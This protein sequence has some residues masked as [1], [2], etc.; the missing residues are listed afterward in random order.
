MYQVVK[1]QK[2][3]KLL[4]VSC[5]QKWQ[6]TN[7]KLYVTEMRNSFMEMTLVPD[8]ETLTD[9]PVDPELPPITEAALLYNLNESLSGTIQIIMNIN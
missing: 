4:L 1:I 8:Y 7:Y 6:K 2:L 3:K 9:D 5:H